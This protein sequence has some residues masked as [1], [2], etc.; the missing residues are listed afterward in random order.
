MNQWS[1]YVK[2]KLLHQAIKG[3]PVTTKIIQ[4]WDCAVLI[5]NVRSGMR[6]MT[7][8]YKPENYV[9]EKRVDCFVR[10]YWNKST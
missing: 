5:I 8:N 2:E 10:L 4:S 6:D 3:E 9:S 1:G 7:L